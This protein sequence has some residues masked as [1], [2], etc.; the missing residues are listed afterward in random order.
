[1]E[2]FMAAL[3]SNVGAICFF[4]GVFMYLRKQFPIIYSDN[5]EKKLAPM[6]SYKDEWTLQ[7]WGWYRACWSYGLGENYMESYD[8]NGALTLDQAMLLEFT[9]LGMRIMAII[10]IPMICIMGPLHWIFG[11]NGAGEDHLS[12]LS[13]GNVKSCGDDP[14]H[15]G[16]RMNPEFQGCW[17]YNIHAFVIWGVVFCV[18][19]CVYRAQA[20]FTK[21]RA[22]WLMQLPDEQARTLL[23]EDIPQEY[24]SDEKLK[25]LLSSLL[26]NRG[27]YACTVMKYL[28]DLTKKKAELEKLK[29]EQKKVGTLVPEVPGA[30]AAAAAL[31]SAKPASNIDKAIKDCQSEIKTLQQKGIEDAKKD[32]DGNVNCAAGFVMF[33]TRPDADAARK[34]QFFGDADEFAMSTPPDPAS[35]IWSDLQHD[36]HKG[37]AW[38]LLGY[39]LI[40]GLFFVYLPLVIWITNI[41][42]KINMGPLQPIWAGL[43]PTMGLQF[44]VAMLPTFLINIFNF[45]FVLKAEVYAQKGL[46]NWYFIFQVVFVI[47]ATAVGTNVNSFLKTI[48]ESPFEAFGL[49]AD[50]MPLATHFYMNFLVLQW[51]THFMNITRYIQLGKYFGFRKIFGTDDKGLQEAKSMAEPEDQDYYGMGSRSA[52]F[53]INLCIGVIF[54]TLS[55]PINLLTGVNFLCCRLVYGYLIPFAETRKPDLGGAFFVSQLK[56]VFTGNIIYCILMIGVL[57]RRAETWFPVVVAAPSLWY[58]IWSMNR[59]DKAFSWENLPFSELQDA[60]T[61]TR[62]PSEIKPQD[63][64]D[65]PNNKYIQP[66]LVG[67]TK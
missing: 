21:I 22:K 56:H 47:L 33:K 44:M 20:S 17:L 16:T 24:R 64:L 58:V 66:E 62:R 15:P 49:L 6:K 9:Q 18:Q 30:P 59:F 4:V 1:M 42:K 3:V 11:G 27:F 61:S 45:C 40:A 10:G 63:W 36:P 53:T 54:G 13:F 35:L 25:G 32:V 50:S 52:R 65:I 19:V 29:Q 26:G 38:T 12:Y 8:P 2:A 43:A 37:A 14:D 57:M 55:P 51:V 41:A 60:K 23:I 28:P 46:Q 31:T 5:V 67:Y 48:G 39:G 34:L 7:A